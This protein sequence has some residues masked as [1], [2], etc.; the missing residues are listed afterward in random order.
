M[1]VVVPAWIFRNKRANNE[2][3]RLRELNAQLLAAMQRAAAVMAY[4]GL[5]GDLKDTDDIIMGKAEAAFEAC[6]AAI[7]AAEGATDVG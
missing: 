5:G 4:I 1:N 2:M 7:A 3:R 6:D